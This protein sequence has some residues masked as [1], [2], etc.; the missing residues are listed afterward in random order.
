MTM[1]TIS[2]PK[3]NGFISHALIALPCDALPLVVEL[4]KR[5]GGE[6]FNAT[7][8]YTTIP[9]MAERERIG[10]MLKGARLRA[11]MTQKQLAVAIDVPQGHISEYEANKRPI[12]AYKA[13]LLAHVLN[14]VES[15][16]IPR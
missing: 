16:F 1:Q 4:V 8:E 3:S 14:T 9:P 11:S 6:V 10:R 12:P 13:A 5:L 2:S 15:H 7:E